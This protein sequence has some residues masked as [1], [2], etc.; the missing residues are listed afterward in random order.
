VIASGTNVK[1]PNSATPLH[2][3]TSTGRP[4]YGAVEGGNVTRRL[5]G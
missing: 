3:V 5:A 2:K 1:L 4:S